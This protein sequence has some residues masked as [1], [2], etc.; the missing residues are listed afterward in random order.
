MGS[1][2]RVK[3]VVENGSAPGVQSLKDDILQQQQQQHHKQHLQLHNG[4]ENGGLGLDHHMSSSGSDIDSE[5]P[6]RIPKFCFE[7]AGGEIVHDP[8][9]WVR[10]SEASEGSHLDEV[11][12]MVDTYFGAA[13]VVIEG[14]NLS[15][16]Q[17]AAVARRPL[18]ELK[19]RL[20]AE[21]AKERV[22][23]SSNWVLSTM[24]KGTDTY[25]VTTGWYNDVCATLCLLA[26]GLAW[27]V[28]LE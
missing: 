8:L 6:P 7:R 20:D 22:D 12:L 11:K 28:C 15:V 5:R 21:A 1:N 10:T 27:P 2:K 4:I 13:E 24:L 14:V 23:V 26:C 16:A 25:G 17:V 9:N 19:V 18:A 3:V